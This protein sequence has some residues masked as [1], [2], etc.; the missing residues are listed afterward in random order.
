MTLKNENPDLLKP[1]IA[2]NEFK[3]WLVN[4]VGE[5]LKPENDEVNVE[6]IIQVVS[7][8]F[9]E[10]LLPIAE[11]NFIRGYQQAISDIEHFEANVVSNVDFLNTKEK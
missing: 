4:Y 9:P 2:E 10:F 8:E 5:K 11:E 6:M 3:K 1:V 7:E